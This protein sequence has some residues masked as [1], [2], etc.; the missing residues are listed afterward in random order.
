[1]LGQETPAEEPQDTQHMQSMH[2]GMAMMG[3]MMHGPMAMQEHMG[4]MHQMMEQMMQHMSEQDAS[5]AAQD[6]DGE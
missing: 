1:V 4:M 2:Q 5:Q 6:E 3:Q